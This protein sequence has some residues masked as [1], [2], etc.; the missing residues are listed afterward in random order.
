MA[1]VVPSTP[2]ADSSISAPAPI[3][4]DVVEAEEDLEAGKRSRGHSNLRKWKL[5]DLFVGCQK[6]GALCCGSLPMM[7]FS[8]AK[9]DLTSTQP[10]ISF[11]SPPL[12]MRDMYCYYATMLFSHCTGFSMS[13]TVQILSDS[14]LKCGEL[15]I[16]CFIGFNILAFAATGREDID[17]LCDV[18]FRVTY[19]VR[20]R[21]REQT[22]ASCV[23]S[24][25]DSLLEGRRE[26]NLCGF[27]VT[28]DRGYG[29]LSAM[30]SLFRRGIN[31]ILIIPDHFLK[32]HPF[33]R[34]SFLDVKW[35][36]E[37]DEEDDNSG[38]DVDVEEDTVS[39][40][41]NTSRIATTAADRRRAFVVDDHA[42]AGPTA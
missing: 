30:T 24:I 14:G 28:A 11:K 18:L 1:T 10:C 12:T 13:K 3:T 39:T 32:C 5:N 16:S 41:E 40:E 42:E 6:P 34:R 38:T 15:S 21:R 35:N 25:I 23:T 33:V 9:R 7:F 2:T 37:D 4:E 29:K 20:F 22:Q 8:N 27:I 17:A 26:R 19:I 36:E 31:C